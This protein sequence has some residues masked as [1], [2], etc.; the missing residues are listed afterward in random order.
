MHAKIH[1]QRTTKNGK[2][3]KGEREKNIDCAT[4]RIKRQ[5]FVFVRL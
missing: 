3:K 2:F 4:L 1:K 5:V